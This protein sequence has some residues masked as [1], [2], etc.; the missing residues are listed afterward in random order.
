MKPIKYRLIDV[1]FSI[2]CTLF[3]ICTLGGSYPYESFSSAAYRAE[4]HGRYYKYARPI[5]DWLF[6]LLGQTEH[7]KYAYYYSKYNLPEDMR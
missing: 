3:S 5:I 4:L 7:C 2:D 6:S 1:L